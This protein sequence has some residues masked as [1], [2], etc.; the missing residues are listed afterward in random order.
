MYFG[1][2][3]ILMRIKPYLKKLSENH[4]LSVYSRLS[5]VNKISRELLY[6]DDRMIYALIQG[7]CIVME[8][9][10]YTANA[11]VIDF[12][13]LR[14]FPYWREAVSQLIREG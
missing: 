3:H 12:L 5:K 8:N 2:S 11:L 10:F 4:A 1:V 7:I 9:G 14:T 13:L 6:R